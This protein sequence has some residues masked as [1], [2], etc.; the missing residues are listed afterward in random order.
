MRQSNRGDVDA[1]I[2]M[3]VMERA[4]A[5][6]AAGRRIVH[7]EV[8]QPGTPAPAGARAA[9]TA[10]M[11]AGPLG[12]TV[13]L[14][15][16]E[17]RA[18]IAR[19]YADWHAVELDPA[20]VVVTSGAS[21][22]FVLAFTALF[23]AG[24][25]VGLGLPG[26]PSYRH[27]LTALS[28]QARG[29]E[30]APEDRYQPRPDQIDNALDG[31]IVASPGNP[32]GTML[33]QEAMAALM[34]R[35][36]QT[37]TAFISDEIYHGLHYD[38]PAVSALEIDDDCIVINSFS[39]YFSMTGWRIGWM[40]VPEEMVRR[41]E[42]LAQNLYICP[43]HA[44]QIA[45]LAAFDCHEELRGNLSVYAANRQLMIDGLARAGFPSFAPPDGAFYVYADCSHLSDDALALSGRIL[46]EAGVAVTPGLDF[47][48]ARGGRHLRFSYA[49]ST[50]DIAEGLER[51]AEWT[52]RGG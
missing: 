14:G 3:D 16:P 47:D 45:A 48:P 50:A 41:V 51:L 31:L 5:A 6:E 4:R 15:L 11:A 10:A 40:V 23:D 17:L 36:R 39:K 19:H 30:T 9:L 18:R 20:R 26:Y 21:A 35:C 25:T 22:G 28:L 13:A 7:M 49:R 1:F 12:Y 2:V 42:R 29:I 44:S 32:A 8:G 46:D 52:R 33:D 34:A 38:R 27:I 37:D 24:E 43:P